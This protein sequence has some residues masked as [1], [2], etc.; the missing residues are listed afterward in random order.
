MKF[1][2]GGGSG[3][4]KRAQH[5][6]QMKAI[7]TAQY[8]GKTYSDFCLWTDRPETC[9]FTTPFGVNLMRSQVLPGRPEIKPNLHIHVIWYFT[10]WGVEPVVAKK[11]SLKSLSLRRPYQLLKDEQIRFELLLVFCSLNRHF[12]TAENHSCV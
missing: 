7:P 2:R 3:I 9:A 11:F 12:Q 5:V 4:P 6:R 8:E 10:V 1:G